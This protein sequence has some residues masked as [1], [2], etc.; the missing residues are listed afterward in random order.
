M[1]GSERVCGWEVDSALNLRNKTQ[2]TV[3]KTFNRTL[4]DNGAGCTRSPI[5]IRVSKQDE[6]STERTE[7]GDTGVRK[8]KNRTAL[9]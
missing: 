8:R 5:S 9:N 6:L 3:G 1:K 2:P 7:S 4:P